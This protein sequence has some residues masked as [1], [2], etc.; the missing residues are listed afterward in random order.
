MLYPL[1]QGRYH[2]E[3]GALWDKLVPK[4]GQADTIQGELVRAIGKL[5]DEFYRNGNINWDMGFRMCTN[6]L[7]RRLRDDKVFN[8]GTIKQIEKDIAEIRGLGNGKN[9]PGCM[10]EG[11][12]D[13]FDR[14][15]DRVVEWCW[16]YPELIKRDKNPKLKR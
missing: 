8:A 16:R 6:F 12:E 4:E 3:Y 14:I 5:S 1:G 11:E 10:E 2:K 9:S 15:T 13:A 7:Y